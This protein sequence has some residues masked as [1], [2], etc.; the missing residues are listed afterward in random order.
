MLHEPIENVLAL[1][2]TPAVPVRRLVAPSQNYVPP[3]TEMERAIS[4]VW[5]EVFHLEQVSVEDNFFEL[6]AHSLLMVRLHLRLC[7]ELKLQL[8]IVRLFEHPSIRALA[9]HIGQPCNQPAESSEMQNRA[10]RQKQALSRF[11][12]PTRRLS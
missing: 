3:Q 12:R 11:Q 6:G 2:S 10:Q 4:R 7:E 9:R 1:L 8:P 5:Q